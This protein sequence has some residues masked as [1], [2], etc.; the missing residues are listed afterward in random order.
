MEMLTLIIALSGVMWYLLDRLKIMW[1]DVSWGKWITL[2][3]AAIAGFALTF[4]FNLDIIF[5]CGLVESASIAG[6]IITGF[7]SS[8]WGA[9]GSVSEISEETVCSANAVSSSEIV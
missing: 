6:K 2:S 7:V 9:A 1:E 5:A 8:V 3:C 4:S